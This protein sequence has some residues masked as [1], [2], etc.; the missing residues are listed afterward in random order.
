MNN[1]IVISFLLNFKKSLY[2]NFMMELSL[3]NGYMVMQQQKL[4]TQINVSLLKK[5]NDFNTNLAQE[6]IQK[7]AQ[8]NVTNNPTNTGQLLDMRV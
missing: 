1:A 5:V 3:V 8:Q 7:L 6:L 2:L 4:M